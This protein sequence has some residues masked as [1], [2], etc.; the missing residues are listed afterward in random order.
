MPLSQMF[1]SHVLQLFV[2]G[3]HSVLEHCLK[4]LVPCVHM[5]SQDESLLFSQVTVA[6]RK[7]WCNRLEADDLPESGFKLIALRPCHLQLV[8]FVRNIVL[9]LRTC[10]HQLQ[11]HRENVWLMS[12]HMRILCVRM[13]GSLI[14]ICK[15]PYLEITSKIWQFWRSLPWHETKLSGIVKCTTPLTPIYG[16]PYASVRLIS[17]SVQ[18]ILRQQYFASTPLLVPLQDSIKFTVRTYHHKLYSQF[19]S[20]N[21]N[22]ISNIHFS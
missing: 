14:E 4:W 18:F 17:R 12:H 10:G 8:Y 1:H 11:A 9:P 7:E 22:E 3:D 15:L 6:I 21:A 13:W 5:M 16:F 20:S 2:S 19:F